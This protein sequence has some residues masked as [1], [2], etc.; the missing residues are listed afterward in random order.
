M[1]K[2]REELQLH[3][4]NLGPMGYPFKKKPDFEN[5]SFSLIKGANK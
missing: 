3:G 1:Q 2:V 4:I 5:L